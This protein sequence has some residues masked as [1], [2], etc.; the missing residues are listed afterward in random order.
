MDAG[1]SPENMLKPKNGLHLKKNADNNKR[2]EMLSCFFLFLSYYV[3]F[4]F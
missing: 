3:L 4:I 2:D 1:Y